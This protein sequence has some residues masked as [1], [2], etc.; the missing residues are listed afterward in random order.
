MLLI[1]WQNLT[2]LDSFHI[3]SDPIYSVF[4]TK[5]CRSY[6]LSICLPVLRARCW[7]GRRTK[8]LLSTRVWDTALAEDAGGAGP[9]RPCPLWVVLV[10][11]PLSL[12]A[13]PLHHWPGSCLDGEDRAG[14]G[15]YRECD[16]EEG[17]KPFYVKT[18]FLVGMMARIQSRHM[19]RDRSLDADRSQCWAGPQ[20][21]SRRAV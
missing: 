13:P 2:I 17:W 7:A 15:A 18:V 3:P 21:S 16:R 11:M 9:G 1:F 4:H 5:N 19:V 12:P 8:L 14:R 20:R 10:D 6:L